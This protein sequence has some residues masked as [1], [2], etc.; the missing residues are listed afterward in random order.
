[1]KFVQ[2]MKGEQGE[3]EERGSGT[4]M[5]TMMQTGEAAA[6][7]SADHLLGSG[8]ASRCSQ[9]PDQTG[10]L[11]SSLLI[12]SS[13]PVTCL[14]SSICADHVTC[15]P[16]SQIHAVTCQPAASAVLIRECLTCECNEKTAPARSCLSLPLLLI[17]TQTHVFITRFPGVSRSAKMS[18]RDE[19][20]EGESEG[21]RRKESAERH[22]VS[23]LKFLPKLVLSQVSGRLLTFVLNGILLRYVCKE[24]LG[25]INVRL[26][27]IY[28]SVQFISREPF[29]RSVSTIDIEN[30]NLKSTV[31][32]IYAA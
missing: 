32:F 13:Q 25:I 17:Q 29:R 9:N 23:S 18:D 8:A 11:S 5:T 15:E 7:L 22:V 4:G 16:K 31:T 19:D 27:L 21:E 24:A 26:L 14:T 6:L 12:S 28:T 10:I 2:M 1:M 30:K 20:E 3:K